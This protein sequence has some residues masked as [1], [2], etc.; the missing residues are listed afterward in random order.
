MRLPVA[1]VLGVIFIMG[2]VCFWTFVF[3]WE[4]KK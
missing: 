4:N 2:Y 3:L 1:I